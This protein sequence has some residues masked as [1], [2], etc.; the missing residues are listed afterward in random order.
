MKLI[1]TVFNLL[2]H[3]VPSCISPQSPR[4]HASNPNLSTSESNTQDICPK[5]PDSPT[6]VSR[7]QEDFCRLANNSESP[8]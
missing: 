5:S 3:Q 8:A 4:L 7:L 1:S 2:Y 6:D